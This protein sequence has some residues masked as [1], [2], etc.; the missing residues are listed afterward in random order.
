MAESHALDMFREFPLFSKR[1]NPP[2]IDLI[3]RL[4]QRCST[5]LGTFRYTRSRV[6]YHC[7]L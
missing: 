4:S 5:K 6:H 7:S 1:S 2:E 3:S